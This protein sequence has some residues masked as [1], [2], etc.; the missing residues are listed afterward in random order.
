[1]FLWIIYNEMFL[2]I[3]AEEFSGCCDK[4][5]N[6]EMNKDKTSKQQNK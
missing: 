3:V 2:N 5:V 6:T 4:E 1:M